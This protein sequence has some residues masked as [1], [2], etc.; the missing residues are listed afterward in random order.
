VRVAEGCVR[1]ELKD[2]GSSQQSTQ[3]QHR[4]RPT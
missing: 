2:Q 4:T 3:N 1:G